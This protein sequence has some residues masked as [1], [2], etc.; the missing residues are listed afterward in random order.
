M[1]L[2]VFSSPRAKNAANSVH[3]TDSLKAI[4]TVD[5]SVGHFIRC[6]ASDTESGKVQQRHI[7]IRKLGIFNR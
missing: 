7:D 4:V 2:S 5:Y 6:L 3:Q 1:K